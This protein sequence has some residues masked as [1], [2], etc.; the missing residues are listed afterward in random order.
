MRRLIPSLL[1]LALL[2]ACAGRSGPQTPPPS[3]AQRLLAA[4]Q[5]ALADEHFS[6]ALGRLQDARE[7]LPLDLA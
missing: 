1:A 5:Q 4:G 6:M 7:G 2:T 3:D